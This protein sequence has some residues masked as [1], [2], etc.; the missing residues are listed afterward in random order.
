M[1]HSTLV[2]DAVDKAFTIS[3]ASECP[4][5][6]GR[7][8]SERFSASFRKMALMR[9]AASRTVASELLNRRADILLLFRMLKEDLE[10]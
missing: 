7:Y 5:Q 6:K 10:G 9:R 1:S 3:I 4:E 8:A 2:A